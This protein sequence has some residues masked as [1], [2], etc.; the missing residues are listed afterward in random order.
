[1]EFKLSSH[2]SVG[3]GATLSAA[4]IAAAAFAPAAANAHTTAHAAA[5][6]APGFVAAAPA[7]SWGGLTL[8]V[9]DQAGT[10]AEAVLGAA[11]YFKLNSGSAVDGVLPD[12]LKVDFNDFAAGPPI[13]QAVNSGADQVGGVG[14]APP[15]FGAAAGYKVAIVNS[16]EVK[17]GKNAALLV[18]PGS[19]ITSITQLIGKK[20]A[21]GVGTSADY[22]FLSILN[23][24]GLKPT[25]F[26]L[27]SDT[28]GT[29]V[30]LLNT[31]AVAA[32]DTWSPYVED[33]V[34]ADN[35]TALYDGSAYGSPWSYDI[36]SE[37]ALKKPKYVA[38]IKAYLTYLNKAYIW[39]P[40]HKSAWTAGW[41][42]IVPFSTAVMTQATDDDI[43]TPIAIGDTTVTNEQG[44]LNSFY[45]AGLLPDTLNYAP[46]ITESFN[47]TLVGYKAPKK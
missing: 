28:G 26:T 18:A 29:C 8:N 9:G 42:L 34:L 20:I 13:V 5:K 14:D 3:L 30:S 27:V 11:G 25:Q 19:G 38:A 24:A 12:G 2:T 45:D 6:K 21:V 1:V 15:V 36:A 39:V 40:S 44:I 41:Q 37:T 10:G 35:D 47:D 22:H 31:G 43:D 7:K 32:C 16:L 4:A 46:Y 17:G 33:A 23:K